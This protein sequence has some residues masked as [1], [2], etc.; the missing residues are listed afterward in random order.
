MVRK[1]F[2]ARNRL[3]SRL[4]NL[5]LRPFLAP[6]FKKR[7][8]DFAQDWIIVEEGVGDLRRS[9]GI[10][11]ALN[12]RVFVQPCQDSR[13]GLYRDLQEGFSKLAESTG[14]TEQL[15]QHQQGPPVAQFAERNHQGAKCESQVSSG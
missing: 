10:D 4:G 1:S 9:R 5:L 12:Q 2:A 13:Q 8:D 11:L 7:I 6:P 14:S 3:V 15:A